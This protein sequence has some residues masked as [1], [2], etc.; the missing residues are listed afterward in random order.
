VTLHPDVYGRARG[1]YAQRVR[2]ELAAAGADQ[3]PV[4]ARIA[5]VTRSPA[6][7]LRI[8][9]SEFTLPVREEPV[10][11]VSTGTAVA[12]QPATTATGTAA[13]TAAS[14]TTASTLA[15]QAGNTLVALQR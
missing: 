7:A 12:A 9:R 2:L 11:T 13:S 8:S 5:S 10:T 4:M 15:S 1:E 3:A 6:T 14:S